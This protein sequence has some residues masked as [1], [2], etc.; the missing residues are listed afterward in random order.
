MDECF[1]VQLYELS[2][3]SPA[4]RES[5]RKQVFSGAC[6]KEAED[7]PAAG[8]W[9]PAIPMGDL[10]PVEM[11]TFACRSWKKAYDLMMDC[12]LQPIDWVCCQE[13]S[14]SNGKIRAVFLSTDGGY[15]CRIL[16]APLL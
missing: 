12:G 14:D 6:Q 13:E 7:F 11:D 3:L 16:R 15:L 9:G 8:V 10:A 1:V 5:L 2:A 4:K